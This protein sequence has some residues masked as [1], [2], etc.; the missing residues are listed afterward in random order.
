MSSSFTFY[1]ESRLPIQPVYSIYFC[2]LFLLTIFST[3]AFYFIQTALLMSPANS[4][5]YVLWLNILNFQPQESIGNLCLGP[6]DAM[7][8]FAWGFFTPS[9]YFLILFC[10]G[11]FHAALSKLIP[12]RLAFEIK[13][14]IRTLISLFLFSYTQVTTN[15]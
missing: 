9:F 5:T 8:V 3:V 2:F 12:S 10:S 13:S 4:N 7:T 15:A 1:P 11:C 6:A 14:Y